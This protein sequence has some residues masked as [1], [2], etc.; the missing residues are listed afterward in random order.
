[1]Q[2]TPIVSVQDVDIDT[3]LESVP[4]ARVAKGHKYP[5][6]HQTG[7]K[8]RYLNIITSFDIETSKRKV[9]FGPQDFESWMYIWQWQIGDKVTI[10]GRTWEEFV[11]LVYMINDHCK[12]RDCRLLCW[13]H[14]LSFEFQ[15]ISG[16]WTFHPED[17]FATDK[18][19]PL[20]CKLDRIEMRCSAR[21]SG[22]PLE[23]WGENLKVDHQKLVG[24][25]DYTVIRYPWTQLTDTELAYCV[26][27]VICVVECV[28]VM[29]E[30]YGDSLYTIPYTATGYIRRRVRSAMRFWSTGAIRAMQ[31]PLYVY[32][33]LRQAFRGGDTHANR[34]AMDVLKADVLSYDRSSSYPDVMC[35]C[36]FP[37]TAF[38]EEEPTMLAI[39]ECVEH[40]RAVLMKI[41]FTNI[42]L[43]DPLTGDPYLSLDK[44][45]QRGFIPPRWN[46]D[47]Y[48]NAI[49]D[50]NGRILEA[51]YCEIAITDIDFEIIDDQYTWDEQIIYWVMSARYGFLPQPLIDVVIGLYRDKTALKG[52]AGQEL[53][54]LHSKQ[55]VNSCYGMM[56]QHVISSPI[57]FDQGKW[58]IKDVDREEEYN[59]AIDKAF[60]CY[61]WAVWVTAWARFRL[62]QGIKIATADDQLNFV[63]AD[64]DSVK[65]QG[66]PD[67]RKYN[68]ERIKDAKSSGAWALDRDGEPHY[69]GVFEYEGKSDLFK[70]LGAKRYCTLK[71]D[72]LTI[73]IAGVPKTTGS[74]ELN[75]AGGIEQ[76]TDDFVFSNSGK[77]T[78]FYND[79]AD[80]TREIDGHQLHITRYVALIDVEYRMNIKADYA[81]L[82]QTCQEL[83]DKQLHPDL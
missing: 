26:H 1:M 44:C 27:D 67:F 37:M 29:L 41:G 63:Y 28:T 24:N 16:C 70:T 25:L 36:K 50:D 72:K 59:K 7:E 17:V 58:I 49:T 56:C 39:S 82:C 69:M 71:G 77:L 74:H 57:V 55:E 34:Y 32:D 46:R 42:R 62:Y 43:K 13:V 48:G 66:N 79:D 4:I 8:I 11:A 31:S 81:L 80:Y 75:M 38:R 14:N 35:H 9:G 21:L 22:Y 15:F 83:L 51:A 2:D 65:C 54:Y 23:A 61:A 30:S 40:G 12:K 6:D 47:S 78:A 76:F 18:R 3:L 10:I 45:R 60:L 20:Y 53:R 5:K 52:I 68:L 64:T 33:R 19:K 73:T